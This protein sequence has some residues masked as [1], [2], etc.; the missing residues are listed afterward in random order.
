MKTTVVK[1]DETDFTVGPL[2]SGQVESII[3]HGMKADVHSD[4]KVVASVEGKA[5]TI[6]DQIAPAVAAS[7]NNVVCGNG[8]WFMR[9]DPWSRPGNLRESDQWWTPEDVQGSILID[10]TYKLYQAMSDLSQL[11]TQIVSSGKKLGEGQAD[12]K[13]ST[14]S[15]AA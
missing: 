3:F 5:R 2:F 14:T 9:P 12:E 13:P 7:L 15:S 10:D 1:I 11:R 4:G 8:V 6:R